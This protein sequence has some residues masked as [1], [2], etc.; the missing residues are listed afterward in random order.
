MSGINGLFSTALSGLNAA[1]AVINTA[2][3]NI[4]NVETPGYKA[5]RVELASAPNGDG[6][7]VAGVTREGDVDLVNE[8]VSLRQGQLLYRANAAV[9]R[10]GD[11]LTGTLLDMF[12]STRRR[13][14]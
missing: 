3:S 12:D 5:G 14:D 2:A 9:V 1:G 13:R 10:V 7:E 6:V 4:A 8:V 11:R